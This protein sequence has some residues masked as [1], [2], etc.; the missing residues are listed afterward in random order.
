VD[1]LAARR[2]ARVPGWLERAHDSLDIAGRQRS[3]ILG[4]D[5]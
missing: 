3:L 4:H 2:L 5:V 1:I